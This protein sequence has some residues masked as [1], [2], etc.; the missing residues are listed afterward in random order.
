MLDLIDHDFENLQILYFQLY[1]QIDIVLDQYGDIIKSTHIT[2]EFL[3][4]GYNEKEACTL[5]FLM[6]L[7]I[8]KKLN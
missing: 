6:T 8:Y 4:F 5:S 3:N 7:L 1:Q 2:K